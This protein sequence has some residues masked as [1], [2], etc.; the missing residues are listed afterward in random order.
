MRWLKAAT[1]PSF[2]SP[3]RAMRIFSDTTGSVFAAV[4]F[5]AELVTP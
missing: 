3:A 4:A 5:A 2:A 1:D